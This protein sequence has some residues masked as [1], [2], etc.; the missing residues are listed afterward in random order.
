MEINKDP[1]ASN[2]NG[3]HSSRGRFVHQLIL[4]R[5]LRILG[6]ELSISPCCSS[7]TG[8]RST[9]PLQSFRPEIIIAVRILSILAKGGTLKIKSNDSHLIGTLSEGTVSPGSRN[10]R[11]GRRLLLDRFL[12]L[13]ALPEGVV[14]VGVVVDEGVRV[15]PCSSAVRLGALQEGLLRGG[16]GGWRGG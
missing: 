4:R 1:L 16:G 8:S 12:L 3:Y 7:P 11:L 10:L 13:P 6:E 9:T 14:D 5:S 15:A 2:A